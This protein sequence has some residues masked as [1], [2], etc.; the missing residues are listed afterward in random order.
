MYYFVLGNG[1]WLSRELASSGQTTDDDVVGLDLNCT[2]RDSEVCLCFC[3]LLKSPVLA[4]TLL[5]DSCVD[6]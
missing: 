3:F 4:R 5:S 6:V 1:W 2:D